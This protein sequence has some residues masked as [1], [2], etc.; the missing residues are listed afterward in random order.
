MAAERS[1]HVLQNV[2]LP[3][4]GE[5]DVVELYVR[6][7][8]GAIVSSA[9][10]SFTI[11][12]RHSVSFD[13]YFGA[14]P[15]GYWRSHTS[16]DRVRLVLTA[17]AAVTIEL[18]AAGQTSARRTVEK[19]DVE[20]T[21]TFEV[22]LT[23]GDAW[24]WFEVS[25]GDRD[26][27]ISEISWQA[28]DAA[29]RRA[30]VC[31]TTFN[32]E[33][34]CIRVLERLAADAKVL[35]QVGRVFVVD[36]GDRKV[37][38]HDG[39]DS[40]AAS[41]GERLTII[42][43]PNLGGSG[44]FSRGMIE[45]LGSDVDDALLLDDDVIL[46]PESISRLLA[47]AA[48]ARGDRIVGAHMLS[49]VDRTVLHTYGERVARRGFWWSSVDPALSEVDLAAL[50]IERT[51]PLRAVHDVDFNGWWMCLVPLAVIRRIG[52]SL[53][54]FIK[55][56]DAEFGLRASAAGIPTVTLPGAAIWHMPW[57]GKDDGLDWQAYYQLRNRVVAALL[58]S[59]ARRGGGILSSTLALDVNH[60]LCLQYGSAE[61]RALALRDVLSGPGHLGPSLRSKTPQVREMLREA[62]QIVLDDVDL[63]VGERFGGPVEPSGARA[64]VSRALRVMAHQFRR[65]RP[66]KP[67]AVD[68]TLT[69][70]EGKWW[71][72]G[73]MDSATIA[74][75]TG[76]GAFVARRDRRRARRL[77][78]EAASLRVRLWLAWPRLARDY[79]RFLGDLTSPSAW[80][81]QF[82][83][84]DRA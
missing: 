81:R 69:R 56:D 79:R 60:L 41:L 76:R 57:T 71:A 34:D 68:A 61:V 23:A 12:A 11:S 22:A 65:P 29:D 78:V 48:R 77:L 2:V 58:H 1:L 21:T 50:W 9:R 72:L 67:Q 73:L 33:A 84:D 37:R 25:A 40:A 66:P 49:L 54:F 36:Q 27:T 43:Q 24:L 38:D 28:N 55:W 17:D 18:L 8:P 3:F 47:F 30:A 10:S 45:A 5:A 53:P 7:V 46:E 51:P 6:A 82:S 64:K 39:F 32:R 19:R 14:F 42:E 52:A 62:G 13:S 15:A 70:A 26:A 75:A 59:P 80:Q 83:L 44:G 35:D 20:G 4:D 74:S 16:V 63:P 31:V